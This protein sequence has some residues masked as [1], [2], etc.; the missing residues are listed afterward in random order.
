MFKRQLA[1]A[2]CLAIM[3]SLGA[4]CASG[5]GGGEEAAKVAPIPANS[6]LAKIKPGMSDL[7][8]RNKLGAPDYQRAHQTGKAWIPYYYG[9]DTHRMEWMYKG[10]GKVVFNQ[11][12]WSGALKVRHAVYDPSVLKGE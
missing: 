4:G 7:D 9:S 10:L 3:M 6:K 2:L 1:S 11:N 5:G 8:V 12:R